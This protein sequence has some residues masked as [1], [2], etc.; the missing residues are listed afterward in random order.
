MSLPAKLSYHDY[1]V[2][3]ICALPLE[4]A[5]AKEMLD[6]EHDSLPQRQN[7]HNNYIL[8]NIGH[9][10]IVLACLPSGIYGTT[11]AAVVS[12]QM[13]SSFPNIHFG[14]LVGIGGGVPTY[15][16][17]RLGDIVVSHP[18]GQYGGVIQYDFGK[19]LSQGRS[20][21]TFIQ[22][23]PPQILLTAIS[24]LQANHF[25]EKPLC[26]LFLSEVIENRDVGNFGSCF[27]GQDRDNLFD[28]DCHHL[29]TAA[30]CHQC[31]K[32]RLRQRDKRS[33]SFPFIHYGLIASGNQVIKDS[34]TRDRLARDLGVKCFEMEAAGLMDAFPCLVIRGICDYADSH[35]NKDWQPYAAIAA[36]AYAK[37][38]LTVVPVSDIGHSS[39]L[40]KVESLKRDI[41]NWIGVSIDLDV[42]D[43]YEAH[44]KRRH[45]ETCNWLLDDT[46]FKNW[47]TY[48]SD[49]DNVLW[50]KAPLGSGKTILS[51]AVI[52]HLNN[53]EYETAYFFYS[54]SDP[55]R[56]NVLDGIR[57]LSIQLLTK[58]RHG[59]PDKLL[60]LYRE[61][62]RSFTRTT[63]RDGIAEKVLG[64]LLEQYSLIHIIVDGL[65]ECTKEKA[66]TETLSNAVNASSKS[67]GL[68]KWFF[69]SREDGQ[70]GKMM[71]NLKAVT[72][73]PLPSF[74]S[75]DIKRFL[76]TGLQ[77]LNRSICLSDDTN[78]IHSD[79]I[80]DCVTL[81]D[82][83][84]LYSQFVIDTLNGN[85]I[86]C[87]GD[88]P[89]I[90]KEFPSSLSG[91]Y[92]RSLQKLYDKSKL[93]QSLVK[94]TF[95][96]LLYGLKSI[97]WKELRGALA[98][99]HNGSNYISSG[100]PSKEKIKE[101]CG[102][103]LAPDGS[104]E[105]EDR[106]VVRLCHKTV[107]DFLRQKPSELLDDESIRNELPKWETFLRGFLVSPEEAAR[108]IG[109]DCLSWLNNKKYRDFS[110][111]QQILDLNE[112]ED[113]FLKYAAAFW[114][115]HLQNANPSEELFAKVREFLESAN[116]WTC[117]VIQSS[118]TPH[119]FTRLKSEPEYYRWDLNDLGFD[120]ND[121]FAVPLPNWFDQYPLG[122][123]LDWD[124]CAFLSDWYNV[125]TAHPGNLSEC[126]SFHRRKSQLG[127]SRLKSK[128][129]DKL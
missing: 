26:H 83:N 78:H 98:V 23:R 49:N 100:V 10:N 6:K 13:L 102:S 22:A 105:S 18:S 119:L 101:L 51:S 43:E 31:D 59:I 69:T 86:T 92:I 54:F 20:M 88:V 35:K 97:T 60:N 68:V 33:I 56:R 8:G 65:D 37:E 9:H 42:R 79:E 27:P 41:I 94:R 17:I 72:I 19:T 112:E 47:C 124:F 109:L 114:W 111:V 14:L 57:S 93:E 81:C 106:S 70:I 44:L 1:T 104:Y 116:F 123:K 12:Q 24:R 73:P 115:E 122:Q 5:A 21:P 34:H 40:L 110:I 48:L 113:S 76:T 29:P 82:G 52:Q 64:M 63:M 50:Y 84:F 53:L 126:I 36:S 55:N 91:Y 77:D 118:I 129:G 89:K 3:W 75:A 45:G 85:G 127:D 121:P 25:Q 15:L 71:T 11:Q 128:N 96:L 117:V 67:H 120:D 38:L 99:R 16:D 80:D 7:D 90:L 87:D 62:L 66:M 125:L 2:G 107:H 61:E 30:D 58:P 4:L 28:S 46:R 39:D 74:I 95:L 103:F 108:D 32:S